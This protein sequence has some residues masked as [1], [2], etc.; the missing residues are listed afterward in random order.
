MGGYGAWDLANH[1]P[2]KL[3][4]VVSM[5]G[6]GDASVAEKLK[7]LP[8]W[9]FHGEQDNVVP[10]SGSQAIADAVSAAGG[11]ARLTILKD[12]GHDIAEV[13]YKN[14]ELIDWLMQQRR[15]APKTP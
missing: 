11:T 2:E 5:C 4:G 8:I 15:S 1:A 10:L 13:A 7:K 14:Q 6:G 12:R 9:V 3:A